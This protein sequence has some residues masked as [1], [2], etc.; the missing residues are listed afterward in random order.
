MA[1]LFSIVLTFFALCCLVYTYRLKK[2]LQKNKGKTPEDKKSLLFQLDCGESMR[3]LSLDS[4]LWPFH[5]YGLGICED[6]EKIQE[7]FVNKQFFITLL[8]FLAQCI[9]AGTDLTY[10]FYPHLLAPRA[11]SL[12]GVQVVFF[13][14]RIL[15]YFFSAYIYLRFQNEL[16][17]SLK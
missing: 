3:G 5:I 14:L 2:T 13:L 10:R 11:F 16:V 4:K 15:L 1:S 12:L 8:Y 9:L 7:A 6:L 17:K